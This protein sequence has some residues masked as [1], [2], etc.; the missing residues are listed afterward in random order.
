MPHAH[1]LCSCQKT[2]YD[3][4]TDT[5]IRTLYTHYRVNSHSHPHTH[6]HTH[7]RVK[8]ASKEDAL[9]AVRHAHRRFLPAICKRNGVIL[10]THSWRKTDTSMSSASAVKTD[11]SLAP[12]KRGRDEDESEPE[13]MRGKKGS[14]SLMEKRALKEAG[15]SYS[16]SDMG[17]A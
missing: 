17:D 15:L 10:V 13:Y 3:M 16:D 11:A 14:L 12:K 2:Q 7:R 8:F 9:N 5:Y 6:T 4:H 1:A